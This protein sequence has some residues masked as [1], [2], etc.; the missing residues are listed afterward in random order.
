MPTYEY[1][2]EKCGKRF[3]VFQSITAE[4]LTRCNDETCGG[5]VKRLFSAGAGFIF[6]GSG[7]YIT[8]YRSDSYKK[9]AQS[10]T[11]ASSSTSKTKSTVSSDSSTS[12]SNSSSGSTSSG[13]SSSS[14]T[15]AAK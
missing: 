5:T 2:C 6:K 7:F 9:A 1:E 10:D 14:A 8:D 12:G 4:P 15:S 11:G 13:S 3:E